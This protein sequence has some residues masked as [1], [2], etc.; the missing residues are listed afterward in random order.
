MLQLLEGIP[1]GTGASSSSE[2]LAEVAQ[3]SA[4]ERA[5]LTEEIAQLKQQLADSRT[6]TGGA[7]MNGELN[8]DTS[9]LKFENASVSC[10]L[11]VRVRLCLRAWATSAAA[12]LR[13][14]GSP[15]RER[16]QGDRGPAQPCR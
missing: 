15:T 4:N 1:A 7:S 10:L 6:N 9:T 14:T 3:R 8:E 2:R 5:R 11:P 16:T 13:G 12:T